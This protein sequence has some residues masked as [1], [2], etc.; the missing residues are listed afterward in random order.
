MAE[1]TLDEMIAFLG[2]SMVW[3]APRIATARE[4]RELEVLT[5]IQRM[6]RQYR[7]GLARLR[8]RGE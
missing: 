4:R 7:D 3:A 5:A 8:E 1:P 2:A 6:L